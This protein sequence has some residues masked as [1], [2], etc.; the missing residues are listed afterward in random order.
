MRHLLPFILVELVALHRSVR[1]TRQL[2]PERSDA[3]WI[4]LTRGPLAGRDIFTREG[5]RHRNLA[6]L[7]QLLGFVVLM[8]SLSLQASA[9][10]P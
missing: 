5:W 9:G 1:A 3:F 10:A 6:L 8:A 2:A 4:W 7:T